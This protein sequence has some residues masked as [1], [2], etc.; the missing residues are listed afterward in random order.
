MFGGGRE[1]RPSG[2]S[3]QVGEAEG[4]LILEVQ[5]RAESSPDNA[6]TCQYYQMVR[7][8]QAR[9][10]GVTKVNQWLNPLKCGTGSNLVDAGRATVR[11][12]LNVRGLRLR[13]RLLTSARRLPGKACGVPGGEA[14]AAKLDVDPVD[15]HMVNVGTISGLPS[16]PPGQGGGGQA[17]RQPMARGWGGGSAVVRGRESR[18]HG[19]GTQRVRNR[20]SG[21]PGGRR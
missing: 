10:R 11:A 6:G 17:H 9:R 3:Q 8:R 14:V 18:S 13:P 15:R 1:T 2:L 16:P 12:D 19:E 20:S 4:S 21:M 7:V 5:G